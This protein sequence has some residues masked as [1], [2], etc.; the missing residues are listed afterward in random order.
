MLH[1]YWLDFMVLDGLLVK[2]VGGNGATNENAHRVRANVSTFPIPF[3]G[4]PCKT[5]ASLANRFEPLGAR[6]ETR[7]VHKVMYQRIKHTIIYC[8]QGIYER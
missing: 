3:L 6:S 1:A 4:I 7:L 2:V 5:S 8:H